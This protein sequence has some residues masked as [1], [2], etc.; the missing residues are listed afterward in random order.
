M[1]FAAAVLLL[2]ACG[3][4]YGNAPEAD[5]V[6]VP[7]ARMDWNKD[8][9]ELAIERWTETRGA[10]RPTCQ[11]RA[12]SVRFEWIESDAE[13]NRICAADFRVLGCSTVD[14]HGEPVAY[15]RADV[16]ANILVHEVLH[17]IEMCETQTVD[18]TH[19]DAH[20]WAGLMAG[21]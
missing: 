9:S 1:K 18:N 15:V 3:P 12:R 10:V 13:L 11:E 5:A 2:A 4:T 21:D 20:L 7:V 17:A 8:P 14:A 19:S 6:V 16:H